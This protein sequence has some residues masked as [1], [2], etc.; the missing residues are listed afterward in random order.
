VDPARSLMTLADCLE[1]GPLPV[2]QALAVARDVADAL[3]A[4][5]QKNIIHRDLKPANI[6]LQGWT[7][8]S[9]VM[10]GAPRAKVL[11][12]GLAK[13]IGVD[14]DE[15]QGTTPSDSIARGTG[16]PLPSVAC[17]N[18]LRGVVRSELKGCCR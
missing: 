12:F 9:K 4:A 17:R 5:H 16:A 8:G 3:E 18:R 14:S 11:D 13:S 2:A 7:A 6:V 10:S 15:D 1:R